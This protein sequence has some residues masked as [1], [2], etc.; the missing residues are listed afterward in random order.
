MHIS[1]LYLDSTNSVKLR[2]ETAEFYLI[3]IPDFFFAVTDVLHRIANIF[4]AIIVI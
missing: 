3:A 2:L 1:R 4:F